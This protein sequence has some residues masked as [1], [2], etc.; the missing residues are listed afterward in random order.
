MSETKPS[1]GHRRV[2]AAIHLLGITAYALPWLLS[3]SGRVRIEASAAVLVLGV[4][5]AAWTARSRAPTAVS[6]LGA[7]LT[8]ATIGLG[9]TVRATGQLR[10]LLPLTP[11]TAVTFVLAIA[12]GV[13]IAR[14]SVRS[15]FYETRPSLAAVDR[16]GARAGAWLAVVGVPP[17][18]FALYRLTKAPQSLEAMFCLTIGFAIVLFGIIVS[19]TGSARARDRKVWLAQVRRGEVPGYR[20]RPRVPSDPVLVAY[21]DVVSSRSSAVLEACAKVGFIPSS[22]AVALAPLE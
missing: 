3:L 16:S 15:R 4:L 6:V 22:R 2:N 18:A 10:S 11:Q 12:F 13:A 7:V 19:M 5:F 20:I 14:P 21:D 8:A 17:L 9:P 1:F